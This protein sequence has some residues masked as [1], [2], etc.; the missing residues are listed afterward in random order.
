MLNNGRL[1]KNAHAEGNYKIYRSLHILCG[2][3]HQIVFTITGR[4]QM[5]ILTKVQDNFFFPHDY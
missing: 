3:R 5:G 1:V 2:K 4:I